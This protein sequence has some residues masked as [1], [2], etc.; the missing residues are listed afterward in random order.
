MNTFESQ[1]DII[2][3]CP[4]HNG[5]CCKDSA[6]AQPTWPMAVWLKLLIILGLLSHSL[7]DQA[8]AMI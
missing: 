5:L 8:I 3:F 2:L 1:N 4:Q 6:S 7:Y